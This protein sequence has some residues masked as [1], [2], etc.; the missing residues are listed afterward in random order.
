MRWL[1]LLSVV[2]AGLRLLGVAW[3]PWLVIIAIP[4][5]PVCLILL[6]DMVSTIRQNWT[7]WS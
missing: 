7:W 6:A 5:V 2:L 4:V 1:V 3:V